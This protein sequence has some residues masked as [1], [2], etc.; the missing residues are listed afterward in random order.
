MRILEVT[1]MIKNGMNEIVKP[2]I[3]IWLK[4]KGISL[5]RYDNLTRNEKTTLKNL[6]CIPTGPTSPKQRINL[7]KKL[8]LPELGGRDSLDP[9]DFVPDEQITNFFKPV[10][11][12][13]TLS[14]LEK[15]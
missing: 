14:N 1:T 10:S 7:Y 12:S 9:V 6:V 13:E 8:C 4:Q 5:K 15:Y 3:E 2:E 11:P